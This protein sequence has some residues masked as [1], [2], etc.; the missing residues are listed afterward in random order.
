MSN[1]FKTHTDTV[2]R[3]AEPPTT[4]FLFAISILASF[5]FC[6][7]LFGLHFNYIEEQE[8][9]IAIGV[10][11]VGFTLFFLL[12]M[13]SYIVSYFLKLNENT[14]KDKQNDVIGDDSK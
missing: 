2:K 11:A 9:I 5:V 8:A 6:Y 4:Y 12:F 7:G 3:F 14:L 1:G 13:Q 10:G